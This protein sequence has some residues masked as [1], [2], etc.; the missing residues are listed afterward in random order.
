MKKVIVVPV[1]MFCHKAVD[2]VSMV[3]KMSLIS[4]PRYAISF[5]T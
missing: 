2:M 3:Q 5:S 4:L 1:K